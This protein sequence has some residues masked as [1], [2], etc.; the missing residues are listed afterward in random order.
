MNSFNAII[1]TRILRLRLTNSGDACLELINEGT[2]VLLA[3][4]IYSVS[5]RFLALL[6]GASSLM[7]PRII[8]EEGI[9]DIPTRQMKQ[10]L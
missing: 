7:Y 3:F 6:Y 4:S 10:S 8:H 5:T 2:V 1:Q 9:A